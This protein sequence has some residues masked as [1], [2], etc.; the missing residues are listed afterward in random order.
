M[1]QYRYTRKIVPV[2]F[3]Y[4]IEKCNTIGPLVGIE[5]VTL[6]FRCSTQP[7]ELQTEASCRAVN[8]G[9]KLF[10]QYILIWSLG[11]SI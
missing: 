9:L 5:P 1:F 2:E 8:A 3:E 7:T 10:I 11:L 6:C 4:W